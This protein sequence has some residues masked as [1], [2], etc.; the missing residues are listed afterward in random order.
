LPRERWGLDHDAHILAF[1]PRSREPVFTR[2][3]GGSTMGR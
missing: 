2:L 1:L 3:A